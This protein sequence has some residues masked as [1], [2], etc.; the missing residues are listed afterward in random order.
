MVPLAAKIGVP[1]VVISI[2]VAAW[3]ANT[4]IAATRESYART[5]ADQAEGIAQL[6]AS[7]YVG[8]STDQQSFIVFLTDI[9]SSVPSVRRIRLFRQDGGTPI[10]W[11]ST[12]PSEINR[13]QPRPE[14]LAP[15][16]TGVGARRELV[17]QGELM[18]ETIEPVQVGGRR[19]IGSVGVFTSLKE[20]DRAVAAL[21]RNALLLSALGVTLELVALWMVFFWLVLRRTARLSR[22]AAQVAAGDL[23]VRL[24][25]GRI[26]RGG[27]ALFK[28][29]REFDRMVGAV[30]ART[31]QQ[32][33]LTRLGQRAL[34]G[35]EL[36]T[37]MD[38]A[39]HHVLQDLEVE[40][41]GILRLTPQAD[42]LLVVAAAGS[43][44]GVVGT[45]IAPAGIGSL[46]GYTLSVGEPVVVEDAR[47]ET[48]FT[49]HPLLLTHGVL[50]SISV[51]IPGYDKP[52]GTLAVHTTRL[53]RFTADEVQFVQAM[54]HTLGWTVRQKY[55]QEQLGE[56]RVLEM[57]AKDEPLPNIFHTLT[58]MVESQRPGAVCAVL[59]VKNGSLFHAAGRRL[60]EGYIRR[61]KR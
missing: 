12:D 7:G 6:V 13:Y 26:A 47:M 16:A 22:A 21:E 59:L 29:A 48:R 8:N 17:T 28:V 35:L 15:I 31:R 2:T 56:A 49:F 19:V 61:A 14:E 60:P 40:E 53:R 38:E 39:A 57:I 36:T 30:A 33:A 10:V 46:A 20:R 51:V 50:S 45:T 1:L 37:L 18:L 42:S 25:E 43:L 4:M 3:L 27:D 32:A 55:A 58:E 11:A 44:E 9:W 23:N 41:V 52:Y 24:P 5:Y 34:E 54:A